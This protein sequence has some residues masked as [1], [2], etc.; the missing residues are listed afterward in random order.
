VRRLDV[1]VARGICV[2]LR[3]GNRRYAQASALIVVPP[4]IAML[5]TFVVVAVIAMVTAI[6]LVAT[7]ATVATVAVIAVATRTGVVVRD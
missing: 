4:A 7:V 2:A 3:V 5:A 6:A 1:H